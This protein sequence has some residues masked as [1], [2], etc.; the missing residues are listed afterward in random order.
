MVAAMNNRRGLREMAH[1]ERLAMIER[2]L[3][4]SPESDPARFEAAAGLQAP[5]NAAPVRGERFRT[6]GIAMVGMGLG[7]AVLVGLTGGSVQTGV[8]I[9][10]AW[11]ILGGASL[12]NYFLISRERQL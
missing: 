6:V 7:F 5:P 2:G 1:R 9:G 4:P 8:G 10:G 11:A 12:V 3:L